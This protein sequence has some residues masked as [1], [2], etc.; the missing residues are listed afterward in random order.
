MSERIGIRE[1]REDLSKTLRRVRAGEALEITDRG[2][3][4]AR[5]VPLRRTG[6]TLDALVAEGK[7]RAPRRPG[8]LPRPLTLRS[9]MTS[10]QAIELLRGD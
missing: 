3:P 1:L 9:R 2:E 6:G 10:E 8:R 7:A 5:L 4:V